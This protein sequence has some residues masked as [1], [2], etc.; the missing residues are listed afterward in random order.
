LPHASYQPTQR[1]AAADPGHAAQLMR[2][3]ATRAPRLL[4]AA[5]AT[6]ETIAN[7]YAEPV[8]VRQLL[9]ALHG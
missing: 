5:A 8:V 4:D 7:R 9:A 6:R 2:A 1:W 3:A